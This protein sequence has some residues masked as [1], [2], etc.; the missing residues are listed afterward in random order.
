MVKRH[1]LCRANTQDLRTYRLRNAANAMRADSK[2][3]RGL[4]FAKVFT[5]PLQRAKRTG[6]LAGFGAVAEIDGNIVEWNYE[7]RMRGA[8]PPESGRSAPTGNCSATAV[9]EGNRQ[10]RPRRGPIA[11]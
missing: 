4:T 10:P 2:R 11:W 7:A 9:Q 8:A 6:E 1:G 3:L 5:S